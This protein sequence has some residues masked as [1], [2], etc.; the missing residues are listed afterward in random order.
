MKKAI[1]AFV[2]VL[3]LTMFLTASALTNAKNMNLPANADRINYIDA[4]GEA[5]VTLV[6]PLP[7]SN[8]PPTADG[9]SL[10]FIHVEIPNEG[11]SFDQLAVFLHIKLTG[12]TVLSWQPMA[13]ITT[14]ADE[15]AFQRAL[16]YGSL[17]RWDVPANYPY[18]AVSTNNV[19]LVPEGVL[20]VERHGNG[21]T[22]NLNSP[23]P[24][25]IQRPTNQ[26]FYLPNFSLK[27][28]KVGGSIHSE[29]TIVWSGYTGASGYTMVADA[30][31]F[32]GTGVFTCAGLNTGPVTDAAIQMQATQTFYPPL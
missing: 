10:K 6:K 25:G 29:R 4:G 9:M 20:S 8:W 15:V 22:V 13:I 16:W 28:D 11:V 2:S 23:Q 31:G 5:N 26:V 1:V 30:M 21:I 7:S 14:N 27:L 17:V 18:P 3:A 32:A 12:A 24:I 19:I